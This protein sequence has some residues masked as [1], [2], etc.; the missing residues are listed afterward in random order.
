MAYSTLDD[1]KKLLP[2]E[3]L[4]QLTDDAG[5]GVVDADVVDEA[6]TY[7]DQLIDGYL[8]GRYTLPLSTVPSFLKKLSIDLVIFYLY[9]RRPEIQNENVEKKY[10]NV[11]RILEQIQ[12][13]KITLGTDDAGNIEKA[14]EYKTNKTS[15]SRIFPYDSLALF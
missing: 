12:A 6:I 9:G 7:A 15:E 13:G 10:T 4:I 8:R 14:G 5:S 11:I 1:I 3:N 2:E